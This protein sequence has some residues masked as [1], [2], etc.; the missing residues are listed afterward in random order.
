MKL[1]RRGVLMKKGYLIAIMMILFLSGCGGKKAYS[2]NPDESS[3]FIA[4]DG[5]LKSALVQKIDTKAKS[6][7]LKEF[8]N[9]EIEDF[10]KINSVNQVKLEEAGIKNDIAKVVFS[11]SSFECMEE[12]AKFTQDNS[13][14]LK[15]VE[16]FKLSD[17]DISSMDS[18]DIP[19]GIKGDYIAIIQGKADVYTEGEIT[20]VSNNIEFNGNTAKVDGFNYII[21]K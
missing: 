9:A 6:E 2:Y 18:I 8:A 12:F 14:D 13:F 7:E 20:Y 17:I 1:Y 11:Y 3:I 21:F 5:T 19:D 16:V 4:K 10:N 15:S